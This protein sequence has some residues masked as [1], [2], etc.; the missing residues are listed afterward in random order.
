[1]NRILFVDDEPRVLGALRRMLHAYRNQWEM[2]FVE[3]GEAALQLMETTPVDVVVSDFR[4]PGMNG[5]KLLTEVRRR[6]PD[7]ARL[8][9]SGHTEEKD[10]TTVVSLAHQFLSK[11]CSPEELLLVV[12]RAL[13]VRRRLDGENVR[14]S[15]SEIGLLP[16]PPSTLRELMAVL[17]SPACDAKALARVVEGDMAMAAKVLQLVNSS[18]FAPRAR[19]TSLEE[20]IVRLGIRTL[21]SLVLMGEMDRS[22]QAPDPATRDRL[23]VLNQH[24][25]DTARLAGRLADPTTRDDAFCAGL[26]HECG[27]LVLAVCRPEVFAQTTQCH[28]L[29]GRPLTETELEK[30]G[31]THEQAGAY[32]LSLWGFP[33]EVVEAV[34]HHAEPLGTPPPERSDVVAVVQLA[35]ALVES[36]RVCLCGRPGH[37]APD[38]G[39]LEEAGVLDEIRSWRE[40]AEAGTL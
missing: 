11:P 34:A 7:T 31:V 13:R 39:F 38:D 30:L 17:E 22:L 15:I 1:M 29:D 24:A 32:L 26:L 5:G 4:M 23:T 10:L 9:L 35:H 14:A 40:D 18:F 20:A 19:V 25:L 16:S 12:E 33:L 2:S 8:V 21:R 36:E 27:Q 28:E 6:Y 3:S 37:P